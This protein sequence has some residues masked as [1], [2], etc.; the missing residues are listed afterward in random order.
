LQLEHLLAGFG[1]LAIREAAVVGDAD[2][3]GRASFG[4]VIHADEA[5]ELNAGAYLLAT[6]PPGRIVRALVVVD[7]ASG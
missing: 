7:E 3:A 4:D 1:C 6:L 2:H 5:G